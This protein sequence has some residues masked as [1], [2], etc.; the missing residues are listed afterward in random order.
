MEHHTTRFA[1]ESSKFA[2]EQPGLWQVKYIGPGDYTLALYPGLVVVCAYVADAWECLTPDPI[3]VADALPMLK[4]P[5][6][7]VYEA[8]S[9]VAMSGRC[10]GLWMT[11]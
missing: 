1:A 6:A 11:S 5:R 8:R 9:G 2:K 4:H 10:C 3:A 7:T